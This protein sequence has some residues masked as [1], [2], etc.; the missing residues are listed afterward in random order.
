[1]PEYVWKIFLENAIEMLSIIPSNRSVIEAHH[2]EYRT[3]GRLTLTF[4][5]CTETAIDSKVVYREQ[6]LK[7]STSRQSDK[8]RL[9]K[10]NHLI[11]HQLFFRGSSIV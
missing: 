9:E 6:L 11:W 5:V 3:S 10:Q 1:M 7:P 8:M 4:P 2:F